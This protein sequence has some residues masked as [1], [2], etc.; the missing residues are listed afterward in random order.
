MV[1]GAEVVAPTTQ[2]KQGDMWTDTD[3][4]VPHT[5][6]REMTSEDI[7]QAIEEYVIAS[8]N[9][10]ESGIDGIEIHFIKPFKVRNYMQ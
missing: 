9:M 4:M 7:K 1:D 10:I 2:T 5:E 6:P 8:K 3:G